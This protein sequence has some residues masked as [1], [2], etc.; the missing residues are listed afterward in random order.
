[1]SVGETM[2]LR[3]RGKNFIL[4]CNEGTPFIDAGLMDRALPTGQNKKRKGLVCL[5]N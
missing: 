2:P 1:M 4:V 3:E 5:A